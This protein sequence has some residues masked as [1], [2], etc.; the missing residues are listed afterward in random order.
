MQPNGLFLLAV[1]LCSF[2]V[3]CVAAGFLAARAWRLT[4]RVIKVSRVAEPVVVDLALRA[5]RLARLG[6]DM[7]H[8]TEQIVANLE[9][10][11][12]STR[13]LQVVAEAWADATK[14]YRAVRDYLGR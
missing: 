6:D 2:L 8:Q 9:R 10:L 7:A 5:E 3:V 4:R 1:G 14:P 12:A 11:A 13:R